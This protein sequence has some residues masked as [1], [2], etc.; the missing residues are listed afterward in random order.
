MDTSPVTNIPVFSFSSLKVTTMKKFFVLWTSQAFSIFGSAV[1]GFALAWYLAKETGSATILTTAMLVNILP[2][3]LLGPFIGPFID[4]WD[5][6]KILIYSDLFTALL[7]L[8]L[9]ILFYTNT[10]QIWHIYVIIAGRSAC[11]AFQLPALQ[12]SITMVVQQKHFVR[13]NGFNQTLRG[14]INIIS[15]AAGA[16]LM[17]A[18]KME[19]VLSVDIFT[20]VIAIGCLLPLAIPQPERKLSVI[21]PKYFADLKQGFQFIASRRGLLHLLILDVILSF[22]AAPSGALLPLF[23]AQYFG[24]DVFKLGWLQT[25]VGIGVVAGG[26]IMGVWSGFKRRIITTLLSIMVQALA[27][28]IFGFTT[29]SL[30]LLALVLRLISGI[31]GSMLMAPWNAILQSVVPK[32]M[33]G[34]VFSLDGSLSRIMMPLS[35][36]IA[37]PVAGVIGLRPVWWGSA[38]IIFI[39]TG[40]A[41]LSRS[42]MNIESQKMRE[43][44]VDETL[45]A[46]PAA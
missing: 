38:A 9:A 33:Q 41:F 31:T 2:Q 43:N 13:A 39:V 23:V 37:G 29:E 22:F 42:L 19:W 28:F 21:K 8:V 45:P 24:G 14:A 1:V 5:R 27:V 12:A 34:R 30:F 16:F 4:R 20:A 35:L 6:K 18:L 11:G 10:V 7:I 25:A 26:L 17:D 3:V 44:P 40:L 46:S 36:A 32:D 15:P